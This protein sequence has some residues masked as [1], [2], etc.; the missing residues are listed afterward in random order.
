MTLDL[1]SR[2]LRGGT[3]VDVVL[4]DLPPGASPRDFYGSGRRYPVLY[5]LHGTFGGHSDWV[6]RTNIETYA[7]E[8]DLVVV[9]P[10]AH[11]SNYSD[12]PSFSLGY[13]GYGYLTHELM[14][15][16]E[17]WL[18]VSTRREDTFIAGLS[19][20]GRGAVKYAVN[21]SERFAAAAVLSAAPV[22]LAP[23]TEE[24][25]ATSTDLM[26]LRLRG[27]A[28]NAG[29][30]D[31][32]RASDENVWAT[33]DRLA[34]TGTL[35]RLL[36]TIGSDDPLEPRWAAFESHAREIGLDATFERREGYSHEWRFWDL[37]VERA[38]DFFGVEPTGTFA[39]TGPRR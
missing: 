16:V 1:Q 20:G 28:A 23:L 34:G 6:R 5:L 27:Q 21:F 7:T 29:G 3:L 36:F 24:Q 22:D 35:P 2:H 32:F 8:R 14:P 11:N 13:D 9:M 18:P 37:A 39:P 30:L 26:D 17:N 15:L 4:P 31:A 12:W 33:I 25:L 19:M 10:T 38:L